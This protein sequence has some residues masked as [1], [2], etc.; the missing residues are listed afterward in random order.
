VGDGEALW[1]AFET[2]PGDAPTCLALADWLEEDEARAGAFWEHFRA[3]PRDLLV[4]L[5]HRS[6]PFTLRWMARFGKWPRRHKNG[7]WK[8]SFH[9]GP[10]AHRL[11]GELF[12]SRFIF[13]ARAAGVRADSLLFQ[14]SFLAMR[15][16]DLLGE[17]GLR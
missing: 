5:Y 11:D 7:L 8:W 4:S 3:R 14:F 13:I 12:D 16:H 9:G 17:L 2:A 10:P 1:R 6:F 15:F